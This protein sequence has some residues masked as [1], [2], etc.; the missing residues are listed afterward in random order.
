M[1]TRASVILL[2]EALGSV[3]EEGG[4]DPRG[5][6]LDDDSGA[7]SSVPIERETRT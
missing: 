1:W 6:V 5:R 3:R 2:P 4:V 7:R